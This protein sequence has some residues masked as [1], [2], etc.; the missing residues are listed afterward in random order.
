M[1]TAPVCGAEPGIE[2]VAAV[3]PAGGSVAAGAAG[4]DVAAG[5]A[6]AGPAAGAPAHAVRVKTVTMSNTTT[7]YGFTFILLEG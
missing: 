6:G 3:V 4:A 7:R 1:R 5:A 2:P